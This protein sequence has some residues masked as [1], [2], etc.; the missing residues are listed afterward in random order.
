MY[1]PP[2]KFIY[3]KIEK[4]LN[5]NKIKAYLRRV[6]VVF[7]DEID[8]MCDRFYISLFSNIILIIMATLILGTLL[9]VKSLGEDDGIVL[10]RDTYGGEESSMELET[11]IDGET[12]YFDI[13]VLPLT[14]DESTI[15][16]AFEKGFGYIE[17]VYLGDNETPD[18]I[19]YD[20]NLVDYID[21]LGIDVRWRVDD[22]EYI[23]SKGEII[24]EVL[25]I[26][27][28]VN[29]TA[30]LSY[31]D[32][33]AER[34]FPIVI[35]G[36]EKS[37][38]ENIV[39]SIKS[40]I[41][42]MQLSAGDVEY[43]TIPEEING[44]AISDGNRNNVP[45]IILVIGAIAC[46][47]IVLRGYSGLKKAEEKRNK[48]LLEAYPSFIDMMTLYMGAG[49]TVKGALTRISIKSGN[50]VLADEI[51]YALN[52]IQSGIPETE[53]Y[54]RL[55]KRLALPVYMK[56]TALLSQNLKKGTRDILDMMEEEE[57]AALQFKRELAKK[58]GE[59]A[60]TKLLFP[61]ITELGIVMVIVILPALMNF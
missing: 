8:R 58:K 43:I 2:G 57:A 53:G 22:D 45:L 44:Y 14:Y 5:K 40:Y 21:E 27:V 10:E 1:L 12:E 20:L 51:G 61:M 25:K 52:E 48:E 47:L 9:L 17:S 36:K 26:P 24:D 15:Y 29:L 34:D 23:N 4:R 60:G 30:I 50:K 32:Y 54:Y 56:I 16:D 37:K 6:N 18:M 38:T 35:Y 19:S 28:V 31:E 7:D 11:Q 41:N 39:N 13:S 3:K 55:G 59:E 49:L 42:E 46:V 33:E